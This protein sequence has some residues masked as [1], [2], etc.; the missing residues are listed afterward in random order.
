[1]VGGHSVVVFM[2]KSRGVGF[3]WLCSCLRVGERTVSGC[4]HILG[5]GNVSSVVSNPRMGEWAVK[6]CYH[7]QGI[8]EWIMNDFS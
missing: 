3:K 6:G 4:V 2:W 8:S 7:I 1:M 5:H